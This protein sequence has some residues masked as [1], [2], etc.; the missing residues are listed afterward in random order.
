MRKGSW[1]RPNAPRERVLERTPVLGHQP[2][3]V[4]SALWLL[5]CGA[6]ATAKERYIAPPFSQ[7]PMH[8]VRVCAAFCLDFMEFLVGS[9]LLACVTAPWRTRHAAA[10]GQN[11]PPRCEYHDL[12]QQY[13]RK[14]PP[15]L[16]C[17]VL[18]FYSY[19]Y[20]VFAFHLRKHQ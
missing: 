6:D 7:R 2:E 10:P 20:M 5:W 9:G 17:R 16:L 4:R 11:P 18:N 1:R 15:S 8:P 12:T 14:I 3:N 19:A 13:M